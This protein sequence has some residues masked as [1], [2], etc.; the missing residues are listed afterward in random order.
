MAMARDIIS[1][2]Q[3][4]ADSMKIAWEEY[5]NEFIQFLLNSPN[6]ALQALGKQKANSHYLSDCDPNQQ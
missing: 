1:N 2:I 4:D 6:S 3:D 5:G